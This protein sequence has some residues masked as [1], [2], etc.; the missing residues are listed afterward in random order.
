MRRSFRLD[1]DPAR[2]DQTSAQLGVRW[3]LSYFDH[4]SEGDPQSRVDA[5]VECQSGWRRSIQQHRHESTAI[6]VRL[7]TAIDTGLSFDGTLHSAFGLADCQ[8]HVANRVSCEWRP[9]VHGALQ[10]YI[11]SLADQHRCRY[12]ES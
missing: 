2:Q 1:P 8:H 3:R 12:T 11:A 7:Y 6:P 5:T 10:P 4:S 9:A